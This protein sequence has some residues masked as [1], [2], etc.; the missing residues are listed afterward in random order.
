MRFFYLSISAA[1]SFKCDSSAFSSVQPWFLNEIF[2]LSHQGSHVFWIRFSC[3]LICAAMIFEW[4]M[5]AFL[6]G[7]LCLFTMI[8]LLFEWRFEIRQ[9]FLRWKEGAGKVLFRLLCDV[10]QGMIR[11]LHDGYMSYLYVLYCVPVNRN[12]SFAC[13]FIT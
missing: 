7:Q 1:M 9:V 13:R 5:D 2:L 8:T 11:R 4:N 6:S 3:F 12:G 10:Q